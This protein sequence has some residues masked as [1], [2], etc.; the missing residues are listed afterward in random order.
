LQLQEYETVILTA[1]GIGIVSILP[2]ALHLAARKNHDDSVRSRSNRDRQATGNLGADT[3]SGASMRVFR[4]A[5]R[6]IDLLWRLEH[7]DQELWVADQLKALQDLDPRR[8][9]LLVW[10]I[11][12]KPRKRDPP[13]Q[14]EH[15][16]SAIYPESSQ[17]A[18][19]AEAHFSFE[20][21]LNHEVL[22]P[23][24]CLVV[25]MNYSLTSSDRS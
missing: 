21:A 9:M 20:K 4:D 23:G 18:A 10:I 13:F 14:E 25:G 12:P 1:K 8:V 15:N 24:K 5:T 7:N 11:Y 3:A 16:W 6:R 2:M 19:E 17:T 22:M